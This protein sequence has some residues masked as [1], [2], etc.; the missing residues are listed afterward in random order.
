MLKS[1]R[2]LA[3][4][5]LVTKITSGKVGNKTAATTLEQYRSRLNDTLE[6]GDKVR[7]ILEGELMKRQQ[8]TKDL[9]WLSAWL[10]KS[11]KELSSKVTGA[12]EDDAVFN[13]VSF[14]HQIVI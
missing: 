8:L 4:E 5:P 3:V 9:Q 2:A 11:E 6:R 14:M 1:D 13:E 7:H 10:E 12:G